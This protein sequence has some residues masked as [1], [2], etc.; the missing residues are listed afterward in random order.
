MKISIDKSLARAERSEQ[1]I[2]RSRLQQD[3]AGFARARESECHLS[4]RARKSHEVRKIDSRPISTWYLYR[5]NFLTAAA[6][7]RFAQVHSPG[8]V[9]SS[10]RAPFCPIDYHFLSRYVTP[11]CSRPVLAKCSSRVCKIAGVFP[12]VCAFR[13]RM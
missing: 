1:I 9:A 11:A 10:I 5:S 8:P 12:Q 6:C 2:I 13:R 3:V 7:M 4:K